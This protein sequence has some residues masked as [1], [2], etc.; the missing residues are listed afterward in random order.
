VLSDN[1]DQ[2]SRKRYLGAI[3]SIALLAVG[4]IGLDLIQVARMQRLLYELKSLDKQK[5]L[6]I[7]K[8]NNL[9]IVYDKGETMG[10][11][12]PSLIRDFNWV[13]S[14]NRR[15]DIDLKNDRV[16]RVEMKTFRYLL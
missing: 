6:D 14:C 13:I 15:I 10:V 4:G 7:C 16:I 1:S 8:R 2:I 5:V 11:E 12:Y 3:Y 9:F